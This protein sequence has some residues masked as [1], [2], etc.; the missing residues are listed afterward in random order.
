MGHTVVTIIFCLFMV[1]TSIFTCFSSGKT[2]TKITPE[3]QLGS[4]A[5]S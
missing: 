4:G 1:E 2:P 5:L 3:F